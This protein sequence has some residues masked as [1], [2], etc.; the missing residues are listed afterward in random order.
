MTALTRMTKVY[1]MKNCGASL[2]LRPIPRSHPKASESEMEYAV[3]SGNTLA[4]MSEALSKPT[5]RLIVTRT[6]A[7][8]KP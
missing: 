7:Q 2:N 6:T 4:A 5:A 8:S 3:E 1:K